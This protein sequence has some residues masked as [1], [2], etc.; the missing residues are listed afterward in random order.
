MSIFATMTRNFS[1]GHFMLLLLLCAWSLPHPVQAGDTI[2][3][4]ALHNAYESE[5][6]STIS[7]YQN[8]VS[9]ADGNRCPMYP[10]CT[11]Y[12]QEAFKRYNFFLAW[13]LISDRLLRCGHDELDLAPKIR[14]HGQLKAYDPPAANTLWWS[15]P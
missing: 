3:K 11:H 2:E 7:F 9:R 12:A 1:I 15:K 13:V 4:G 10:S 6:G 14:I 8:I 5:L